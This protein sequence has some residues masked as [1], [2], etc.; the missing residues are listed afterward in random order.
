MRGLGVV[1]TNL[2]LRYLSAETLA[3]YDTRVLIV[4]SLFS[5]SAMILNFLPHSDE[6][7]TTLAILF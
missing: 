3:V 7:T 1:L 2:A 5:L 4:R 6:N